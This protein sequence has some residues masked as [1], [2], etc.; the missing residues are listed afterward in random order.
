MANNNS[1]SASSYEIGYRKPPKSTQFKP[2]QSGNPSGK[3]KAPKSND[4]IFQDILSTKLKVTKNGDTKQVETREIIAQQIINSAAKSDMPAIRLLTQLGYLS[5]APSK[6][7]T[8]P[9]SKSIADQVGNAHLE[10]L[11]SIYDRAK[12]KIAEN[13]KKQDEAIE[14][15][16]NQPKA[17]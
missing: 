13:E 2:G 6:S 12:A 3:K 9:N 17:S 5:P 11:K 8:S 16:E 4:Q 14:N 15:K 10:A 7:N 1:K